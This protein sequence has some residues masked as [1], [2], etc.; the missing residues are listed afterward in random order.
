MAI[1]IGTPLVKTFPLLKSDPTGEATITVRQGTQIHHDMISNLFSE[2]TYIYP[3]KDKG[4]VQQKVRY[5]RADLMRM[6]IGFTLIGAD[7][8]VDEAG[9]PYFKFKLG[10]N[11][12]PKLDMTLELFEEAYGKITVPGLVDEMFEKVVELN[13]RWN[14]DR[15]AGQGEA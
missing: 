9:A 1:K 7:H 3:D 14:P 13:P 10:E 5:S 4:T 6:A 8:I 12:Q 11:S 2:S 15:T